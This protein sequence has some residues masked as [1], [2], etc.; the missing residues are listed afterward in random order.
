MTV[1]CLLQEVLNYAHNYE[2]VMGKLDRVRKPYEDTA[3]AIKPHYNARQQNK[4]EQQRNSTPQQHRNTNTQQSDTR[5]K[6]GNY[7]NR[8]SNEH[9]CP[10]NITCFKRNEEGHVASRCPSNE[11]PT[12]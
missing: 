11:Q 4:N 2:A 5:P 9:R 1:D 10:S 12:N 6:R 3:N 7:D 8:Q